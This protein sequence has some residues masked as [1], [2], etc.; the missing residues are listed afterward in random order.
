MIKKIIGG[1]AFVLGAIGIIASSDKTRK[2]LPVN[3]PEALT[4]NTLLIIGV[5]LIILGALLFFGTKK[6][7]HKAQEIPVYEGSRIVAYRR[8]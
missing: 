2:L 5:V 3:L 8:V 4:G 7:N 1:I 6:H